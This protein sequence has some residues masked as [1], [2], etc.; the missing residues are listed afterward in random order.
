MAEAM[1]RPLLK[2]ICRIGHDAVVCRTG[3]DS[4]D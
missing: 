2:Y 1:A 4:D 3:V